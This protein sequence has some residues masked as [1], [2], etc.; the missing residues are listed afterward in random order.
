[1]A[2]NNAIFIENTYHFEAPTAVVW[3]AFSNTA[4]LGELNGEAGYRAQ[5]ELQSDGSVIRRA[6]GDKFG[7]FVTE[8]VEDLGEWVAERYARSHRI[9][10]IGMFESATLEA[11][12]KETAAGSSLTVRLNMV[13]RGFIGWVGKTFGIA[14]A[15]MTKVLQ[16]AE[17]LVTAEIAKPNSDQDGYSYLHYQAPALQPDAQLR[18]TAITQELKEIEKQPGL[19]ERLVNYLSRAPEV[20]LER[21]RPIPLAREWQ[22]ETADVID[23]CLAATSLGLMTLRWEV[24][25]PRCQNDQTGS[26]NL[27]ELPTSVH[28]GTCNIDYD[29]DFSANVELLFAPADWLR[30]MDDA[31]TCLMGPDSVPHIKVQRHVPAGGMLSVDP[32][33]KA[34]GYRVRT[35]EAGS[36][37]SY[38]WDGSEPFPTVLLRADGEFELLPGR[39]AEIELRNENALARTFVIEELGWRADALTGDKAIASTAFRRYCPEQLLSPGD[40]V[41]IENIVFLFTDLKGSTSL[42][43]SIGDTAAYNLVRDHFVYLTELV[44]RYEGTLVKTMGD[45]VMAVF[46]NPAN[47]VE[48]AIMAQSGVGDFNAGRNDQGMILKIGLHQGA[49]IAVTNDRV[50]DYFGS[51]VNLSSRL[52]NTSHGGDIVLS[53]ALAADAA[54]QQVI[55]KNAQFKASPENIEVKGIEGTIAI[56]R[57]TA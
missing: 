11:E 30:P 1:M 57:L 48:A 33:L 31:A 37:R 23:I 22:Q 28:C 36:E 52:E 44:D 46:A 9:V 14:K 49:C 32:P 18:L 27:A 41:R 15:A 19:S 13:P 10:T 16:N 50:L 47:A 12:L 39:S 34:G 17:S 40:D 24:L 26:A 5:N 20:F 7:P 51:T 8:W 54:V 43:E 53:A 38:D 6:R 3:R 42:Y 4:L 55:K 35:A 21:I 56:V 25:C 2:E 45:A 29:R